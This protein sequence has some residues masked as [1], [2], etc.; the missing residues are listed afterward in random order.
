MDLPAKGKKSG[1]SKA[2]GTSKKA[3]TTKE[4]LRIV[5][6]EDEMGMGAM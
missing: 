6:G 3:K 5:D 2:K 1:T 4:R